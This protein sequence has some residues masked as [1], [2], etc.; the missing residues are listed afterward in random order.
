M[1]PPSAPAC[2]AGGI[3]RRWRNR[4]PSS[5][6]REPGGTIGVSPMRSSARR[7]YAV[8][9]SEGRESRVRVFLADDHAVL[10]SGLRLLVNAQPD[11]VVVGEA[12]D[13]EEAV[14]R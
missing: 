4:P 6:R 5:T 9:M 1:S 3:E 2:S 12:G 10:R 8:A 7:G 14:E 11:L 13:G